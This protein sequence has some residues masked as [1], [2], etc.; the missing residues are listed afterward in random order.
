[1]TL[2]LPVVNKKG[3]IKHASSPLNGLLLLLGG[4]AEHLLNLTADLL[5]GGDV[6]DALVDE[7]EGALLLT[8]AEHLLDALLEGV[9]AAELSDDGLDGAELGLG[10]TEAGL[11]GEL[12]GAGGGLVTLVEASDDAGLSGLGGGGL[13]LGGGHGGSLFT[14]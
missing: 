13:T 10:G 8:D 5:G 7:L 14:G 6:T 12:G 2:F 11:A 3:I 1:M 4:G 9:E